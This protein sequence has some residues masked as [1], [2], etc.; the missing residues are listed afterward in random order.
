MAM[1]KIIGV[2]YLNI[3]TK[4]IGIYISRKIFLAHL[5]LVLVFFNSEDVYCH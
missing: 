2:Y 5:K 1:W 4:K 3:N